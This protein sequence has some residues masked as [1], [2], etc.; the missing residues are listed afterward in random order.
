MFKSFKSFV[1]TFIVLPS[2]LGAALAFTVEILPLIWSIITQKGTSLAFKDLVITFVL[3]YV[4]YLVYIVYKAI[5]HKFNKN[6]SH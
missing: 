3:G 5:I 6:K 4:M 1:I 2:I